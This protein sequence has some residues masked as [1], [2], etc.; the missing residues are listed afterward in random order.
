MHL[1]LYNASGYQPP[2]GTQPTQ[3]KKLQKYI[4]MY[5]VPL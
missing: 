2:D 5:F 3:E 4:Q 1:P